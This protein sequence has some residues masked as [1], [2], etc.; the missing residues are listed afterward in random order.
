MIGAAHDYYYFHRAR[1]N[2]RGCKCGGKV[3]PSATGAF[4][5]YGQILHAKYRTG[6]KSTTT[7]QIG[8]D[9]NPSM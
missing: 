4:A 5:G 6:T 7:I 2:L 9:L 1:Q 3:G 8:M